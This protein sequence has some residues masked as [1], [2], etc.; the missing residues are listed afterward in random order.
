MGSEA[1]G[2]GGYAAIRSRAPVPSVIL[3]LVAWGAP[4][5]RAL[6]ID[7]LVALRHE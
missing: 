4:A 5:R 3:R 1:E 6:R 2:V 7:P